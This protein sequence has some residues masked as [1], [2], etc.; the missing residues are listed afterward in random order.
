MSRA[1][2]PGLFAG[3]GGSFVPLPAR[4]SSAR[5]PWLSLHPSAAQLPA[6]LV[7]VLPGGGYQR[8]ADHEAGPVA[9]W[10]NSLGLH[11]AVLRYRIGP[12]RHPEPLQDALAA[13]AWARSGGAGDLVDTSRIGVLGFS[14]GGHLAATL[15]TGGEDPAGDRPDLAILGYPVVSFH[16]EPHEGSVRELLGPDAP[17]QPRRELSAELKVDGR[18]PATFLW[19]TAEDASVPVSHSLGYASALAKAGV[20]VELHVFPHGRHG[21]GLAADEP[22]AGQWPEL[23]GRWLAGRGWTTAS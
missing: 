20:P 1:T 21:L 15:C 3:D 13:L 23:C 12:T 10:L 8:H 19:H 11:A 14:A 6:P 18:T 16:T 4:E 9:D 2:E 17:E 5:L 7:L 22:G